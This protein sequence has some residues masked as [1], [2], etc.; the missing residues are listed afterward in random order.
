MVI[1]GWFSWLLRYWKVQPIKGMIISSGKY[2]LWCSKSILYNKC[3][4]LLVKCPMRRLWRI[5]RK[6]SFRQGKISMKLKYISIK[7]IPI[8]YR[9]YSRRHSCR[10]I[11]WILISVGIY[12]HKKNNYNSVLKIEKWSRRV[13][14]CLSL[15]YNL[16]MPKQNLKKNKFVRTQEWTILM[17]M[18]KIQ[19]AQKLEQLRI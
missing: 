19:R 9:K 14:A 16:I 13:E 1:Y 8:R 12:C 15:R 5:V 2:T 7:R 3:I 6:H 18:G 11:I 10:S 17:I 4:L